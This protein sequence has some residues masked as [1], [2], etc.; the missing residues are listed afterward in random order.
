MDLELGISLGGVE[1]LDVGGVG[2]KVMG[3]RCGRGR[4]WIAV[5]L[6]LAEARDRR[7]HG[8]LRC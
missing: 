6:S 5:L 1:Q 8:V 4:G 7:W 2:C 3:R